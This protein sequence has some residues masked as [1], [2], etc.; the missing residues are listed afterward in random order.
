MQVISLLRT[1]ARGGRTIICVIHQPSSSIFAMFDRVYFLTNGQ[2]IYSG[3]TD[4]LVRYLTTTVGLVCPS[5]HNPADFGIHFL[6]IYFDNF[7][8]KSQYL[9]I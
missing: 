7:E 8:A 9:I 5:D 1:L 2:C 4:S 6:I 3:P